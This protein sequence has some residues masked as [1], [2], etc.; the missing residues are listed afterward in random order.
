MS[1]QRRED[2]EDTMQLKDETVFSKEKEKKL[3]AVYEELKV[4]CIVV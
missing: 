4:V 2:N 3:N 1:L